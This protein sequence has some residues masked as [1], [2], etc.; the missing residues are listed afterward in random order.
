MLRNGTLT[1]SPK[2]VEGAF[3]EIHAVAS[4]H[5][6]RVINEVTTPRGSASPSRWARSRKSRWRWSSGYALVP[7]SRNREQGGDLRSRAVEEVQGGPRVSVPSRESTSIY[8]GT[9]G[10]PV[11][12]AST[13][14]RI[15]ALVCL[16]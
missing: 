7:Y 3:S 16:A 9:S 14:S 1:H 6:P 5:L 12:T 8:H 13:R 10:W 4:T 11:R 2:R 15:E